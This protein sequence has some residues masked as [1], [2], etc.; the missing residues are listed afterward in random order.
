MMNLRSELE[1]EIVASGVVGMLVLA[2]W[3]FFR[4][5]SKGEQSLFE[6]MCEPHEETHVPPTLIPHAW[7]SHDK[8]DSDVSIR[9]PAPDPAAFDT[10]RLTAFEQLNVKS[11]KKGEPYPDLGMLLVSKKD[12]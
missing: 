4:R 2:T 9:N 8:R 10:K 6:K 5:D 11:Q 7:A 12:N 3:L 1:I